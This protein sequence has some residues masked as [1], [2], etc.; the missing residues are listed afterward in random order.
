MGDMDLIDVAQGQM[1]VGVGVLMHGIMN[2]R[3]P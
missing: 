2:C 1:G 3:V